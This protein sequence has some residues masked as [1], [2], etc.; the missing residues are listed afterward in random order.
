MTMP[1]ASC[2]HVVKLARDANRLLV[3]ADLHVLHQAG[4]KL[5]QVHESLAAARS[6]GAC[7]AGS[8]AELLQE[9]RVAS[10]VALQ[11][12]GLCAELL[13]AQP[14]ETAETAGLVNLLV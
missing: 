8:L 5:A 10:R 12:A 1:S 11:A 3:I 13:S 2:P 6:S 9:L 14:E 4:R 7:D